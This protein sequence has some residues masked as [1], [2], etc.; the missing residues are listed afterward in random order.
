MTYLSF[1]I[2]WVTF[3]QRLIIDYTFS[4]RHTVYQYTFPDLLSCASV[5]RVNINS[6]IIFTERGYLTFSQDACTVLIM[7]LV[8]IIYVNAILYSFDEM[9]HLLFRDDAARVCVK[10]P[11]E[12]SVHKILNGLN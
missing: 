5:H 7:H 11:C 6:S 3:T 8:S 2:I 1:V 12:C 9:G 4:L 10:P